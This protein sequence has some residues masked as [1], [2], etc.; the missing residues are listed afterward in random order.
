MDTKALFQA[1]SSKMHADFKA[2]AQVAHHGSKGTIRENILR[3]FLDEGRLPSKYGLGSGEI[4]GRIKDTSRQSDLIIYDKIDGVTL[5]Y[6]EHT[7]VYPIDCVYGI[8]EV[9]SAL[10]KTEFIDA[11]DKIA[12]FK[13]MA[14]GGHVWLSR[15]GVTISFPRPRPF[16]M[17]FA[18]NLAGNSLDSLTANLREWEQR[19]PPELWPNYVCVLGIGTIS[20]QGK[21]VF[22]KCLDSESIT[23]ESWPFP[24]GYREDSL[25]N[26][27]SALHDL[28]A[29]MKLGPVE[30]LTY[31][32]P[33]QRIGRFVIDGRFEF[34]RQ[35]DNAAVRPNEATIARIVGWCGSQGPMRRE[36]YFLKRF[37]SVPDGL[38]TRQL[39]DRHI[40]LYNPDDLPGLHELGD[41]P[42]HVDED[43]AR[44]SQPSLLSV[45]EVVIDGHHYAVCMD[46]L[47]P[48]D[49]EDVPQ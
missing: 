36:D 38:N 49:F 21:D 23:T 1:I 40:Y 34:R 9:K 3:K 4:V 19:H 37:G 39:L 28:C 27:Y 35:S 32:E 46:S 5:L 42:F 47:G 16:G 7:Q 18:Y 30:L 14:P 13:S 41:T 6:D 12:A 11:L 48:E 43:G 2:S 26:F 15:G 8:I 31:Y 45:V 10:S 17:I 22:Q 33:L 20:H 29:R 24:L 25:W 44:S